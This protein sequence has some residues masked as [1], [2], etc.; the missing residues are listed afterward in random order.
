MDLLSKTQLTQSST[1]GCTEWTFKIRRVGKFSGCKKLHQLDEIEPSLR[2]T[3]NTPDR[4][5]TPLTTWL[6]SPLNPT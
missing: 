2:G 6:Q 1:R 5:V 3:Y 4:R